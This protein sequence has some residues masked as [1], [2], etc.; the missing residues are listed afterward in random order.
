M[1]FFIIILTT[2]LLTGCF[3]N[4]QLRLGKYSLSMGDDIPH[5]LV[6][7]VLGLLLASLTRIST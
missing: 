3:T 2:L 5:Y 4:V 7:T 6:D 1:K